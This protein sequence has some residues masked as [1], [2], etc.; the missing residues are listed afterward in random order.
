MEGVTEMKSFVPKNEPKK[1]ITISKQKIAELLTTEEHMTKSNAM[2][3]CN[4]C[5]ENSAVLKCWDSK[6]TGTRRCF[7]FCVNKGCR[8]EQ[9]ITFP[10]EAKQ[11]ES[12]RV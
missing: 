5:K 8:Y 7:L 10:R 12:T 1:S 3:W 9:E 6:K 4:H 2:Y 11:Y